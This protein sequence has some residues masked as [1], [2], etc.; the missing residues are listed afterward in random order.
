MARKC[1]KLD[2]ARGLAVLAALYLTAGLLWLLPSPGFGA[3]RLVFFAAV[4]VA[5]WIGAAGALRH[6]PA[7]ATVGGLGLVLFGFWQAVLWIFVLPAAAVI[8]IVAAI[9][10]RPPNDG[11][12]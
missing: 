1:S 8:L 6:R 4:A 2:L 10:A 12:E 3:S 11:P 5:G 7:L 9:L